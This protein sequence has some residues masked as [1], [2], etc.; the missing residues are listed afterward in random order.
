MRVLAKV[1]VRTIATLIAVEPAYAADYLRC[2][3]GGLPDVN[4][5]LNLTMAEAVKDARTG[6]EWFKTHQWGNM[7]CLYG[8]FVVDMSACA[9]ATGGYGFSAPTGYAPLVSIL[10]FNYLH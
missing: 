10:R 8:S 2:S 3:H 4:V 7:S 6:S 9:P 1:G 5:A